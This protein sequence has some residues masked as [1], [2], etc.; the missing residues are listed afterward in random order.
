MF[1]ENLCINLNVGDKMIIICSIYKPPILNKHNF[2]VEFSNMLRS[3]GNDEAVIV[4]DFNINVL[5]HRASIVKQ[6]L[7]T[8]NS[9]G[10]ANKVTE[11]TRIDLCNNSYTLIDHILV[12]SRYFDSFVKVIECT[13]SDHFAINFSLSHKST[14]ILNKQ[15]NY[16]KFRVNES[17]LDN[18]L[19]STR[20][21][22][23]ISP[24]P[25][26]AAMYNDC[27][28]YNKILNICKTTI[29]KNIGQKVHG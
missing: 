3:F 29:P 12:K 14:I 9:L 24:K 26:N 20:W 23:I 7:D 5:D 25:I 19:S 17:K 1:F 8:I 2:L 6:Y 4:G 11:Y 27:Q 18:M 13:I 21:S 22:D 15:I 16:N 10:F 28:E